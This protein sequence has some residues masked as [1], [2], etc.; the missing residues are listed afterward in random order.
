M[1]SQPPDNYERQFDF[2]NFSLTQPAAQ[3]PGQQIDLELDEARL[4]I[5]QTISRLNE[6]QRDDGKLRDEF[7]AEA[8]AGAVDAAEVQR[9]MAEAARADTYTARA[10]VLAAETHVVAI[11]DGLEALANETLLDAE[12]AAQSAEADAQAAELSASSAAS[13]AASSSASATDAYDSELAAAASAATAT[14]KAGEAAASAVSANNSAVA[15]AASASS[16][17]G[18]SFTAPLSRLGDVVSIDLSAYYL[19]SNPSGYITSSALTGYATQ[20]YVTSQG[21]ITSSA[22]TPY[23]TTATAAATYFPKPTGTSAQYIAGDG[24]LITFPTLATANKLT[25]T[26]SNQTGS[27]LTKGQVVYINGTH[28]NLPTVAL[29]QANAEVTSAGTYGFVAAD[30]GNNSTGTIVIAGIVENLA[31]N[32]LADGDKI[33]LSPTVAGGYTTTKPYAPNHMVYLGVV[34][35]AHPDLGTI[36]L[37]IQN[38]FELDELHDVQAQAPN[39][40]DGIF[41]DDADNQW[42]TASVV[43]K[44]PEASDTVA[45]KVEL[46]TSAEAINGTSTTLAITPAAS[47]AVVNSQRIDT[48]VFGSPTT[49]GAYTWTKPDGA[50]FVEIY[51]FSGGGGGASGSRNATTVNRGGGGG[52]AGGTTVLMRL[53]ADELS[54]VVSGVVGAGGNGA[55]SQLTDTSPGINGSNGG[56]TTFGNYRAAFGAPGAGAIL[57]GTG[58]A[59]ATKAGLIYGA[60]LQSGGGGIGTTGTVPLAAASGSV[61]LAARGASGGAGQA[62]NVLTQINGTVGGA[63]VA[64]AGTISGYL[65]AVAG[66][67]GGTNAIPDGGDGVNS[68]IL[69]GTGTGGGSGAYRAANVGGSGG[70]GGWPSGGGGGG[71]GSDNGFASGAGGKGANGKVV[72]ITYF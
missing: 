33:Y 8:V 46:A 52:A 40:G 24:T 17:T 18:L 44:V 10:E 7:V 68:P 16:I 28:G 19:A 50:K 66:G 30:I 15:A 32:L 62:A 42:K 64:S 29:A 22:L 31:T 26:V 34:T 45:G 20:S 72:V 11:A 56:D 67:V 12:A 13:S 49:S 23:I 35:R 51:L 9:Q 63:H 37:R 4:S 65:V 3:Q 39:D 1:P 36:Q 60:N 70:D 54:E 5:N 43:S 25:A 21:Y 14:T 2:T 41:F 27:V 53:F 61:P 59:G 58:S 6:I 47:M 57:N 55:P 71:S 69:L 38:G 48:Q